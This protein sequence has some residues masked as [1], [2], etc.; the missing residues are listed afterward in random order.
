MT[1]VCWW[2]S[3][4][5]CG[6]D[7]RPILLTI[8][9]GRNHGVLAGRQQQLAVRL[10]RPNLIKIQPHV[11]AEGFSALLRARDTCIG[12]AAFFGRRAR[13]EKQRTRTVAVWES[14]KVGS[15]LRPRRL[16][17]LASDRH[18]VDSTKDD[19][20]HFRSDSRGVLGLDRRRFMRQTG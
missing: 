19:M 9:P 11:C 10:R 17:I 13:P 4:A 16:D 5:V 2:R 1:V 20:D 12:V 14:A 6:V 7:L 3:G 8:C 15:F 18:E